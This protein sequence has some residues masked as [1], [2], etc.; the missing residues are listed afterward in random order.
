MSDHGLWREFTPPGPKAAGW[1]YSNAKDFAGII[2]PY[3]SAK[4]TT[5]AEKCMRVTCQQHPSTKDG[6]RKA[7]IPA[8]RPNYRRMHDTLIPS[9]RKFFGKDAQWDGPKN[10]P[11]DCRMIWE[12]PGLGRCDM[13][14]A[15]RAIGD[16]SIDSFVRG[17][18]PTSWWVNEFDELPRGALSKM[19]SRIGRHLLH[20]KPDLPPAE[21]CPVFGDTNMPDLDSWVHDILLKEPKAGTEIYLQPSGLSPNAENLENLHKSDPLY[22]ENMKARFEQEGD[23]ASIRRFIENMPGY[24]PSGR[25]VYPTFRYERHIGADTMKPNR[26]KRLI[27]GV[28]QGGQAS[29][30]IGQQAGPLMVRCFR[31]IVLPEGAFYGGKEFGKLLGRTMLDEFK[32]WL[33]PG[34]FIIRM[35]PAAKQRHSGSNEKE[36]SPRTWALDCIDGFIE[37]TGFSDPDWDIAATNVI[38]RR[39]G[40]VRK[41]LQHRD[42]SSGD[43]GLQIHPDMTVTARGFAGGYRHAQVQGRPGEYHPEPEKG[44]YSN[45]HDAL[46]YLALEIAPEMA[47]LEPDDRKEFAAMTAA[48]LERNAPAWGDHAETEIL[49]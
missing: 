44:R 35:D 23:F 4:T 17:F 45:P 29:A 12:E 19:A 41:L 34:G 9:V 39:I 14:I 36:N 20:E 10:G 43:E 42:P 49:F 1:L 31:E 32:E 40:A 38:K 16:E 11:Q 5:G 18:E 8:V 48:A 2:G 46:Q 26:M 47:G 6:V 30:I 15:F 13:T 21:F 27:I 7:L 25:P 22:Y 28:D 37:E 3:G 24:T 33:A